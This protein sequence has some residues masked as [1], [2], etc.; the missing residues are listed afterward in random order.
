VIWWRGKG[1]WIGF[2]AAVPIVL[3]AGFGPIHGAL[4]CLVSALF[5]FVARDWLGESSSLFSIPVRWW[6]PLM[7]VLAILIA[8]DALR[9]GPS[10]PQPRAVAAA[11]VNTAQVPASKAVAAPAA[12]SPDSAD[13]GLAQFDSWARDKAKASDIR[14]VSRSEVWLSLVR[15]PQDPAGLARE[16]AERYKTL[17]GTSVPTR[18]VLFANNARIAEAT[19]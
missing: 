16:S 9:H 7:A 6:P 11:P 19:E 15:V 4:A 10:S 1:L 8:L 3:E 13:S 17:M 2:I 14:Y 12:Q 18:V 5:I